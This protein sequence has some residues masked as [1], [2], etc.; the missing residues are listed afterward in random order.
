M[1]YIPETKSYQLAT[2][3]SHRS[4]F[5]HPESKHHSWMFQD[6]E[7]HGTYA[8]LRSDIY[9]S[10]YDSLKL[11]SGSPS[12]G[13]SVVYHSEHQGF[14]VGGCSLTFGPNR[15]YG[16]VCSHP[17]SYLI[18]RYISKEYELY[19]K[20]VIAKSEGINMK[21][22]SDLTHLWEKDDIYSNITN[23]LGIFAAESKSE[24][25]IKDWHYIDY[26]PIWELRNITIPGWN[27]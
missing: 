27:D 5:L 25:M 21:D 22:K 13:C 20:D 24:L 16:G 3:H 1:D 6:H 15:V 11:A 8:I 14:V 10:Y 18:V 17:L 23:G 12:G 9:V 26:P 4:I 19:I 7:Y 2:S